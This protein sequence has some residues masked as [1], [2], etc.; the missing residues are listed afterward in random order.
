MLQLVKD[1]F[2]TIYLEVEAKLFVHILRQLNL[3][4]EEDTSSKV[5]SKCVALALNYLLYLKHIP[6]HLSNIALDV[7]KFKQSHTVILRFPYMSKHDFSEMY[8]EK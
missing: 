3:E 6:N 8:N 1:S 2:I 5:T 4:E 7:L